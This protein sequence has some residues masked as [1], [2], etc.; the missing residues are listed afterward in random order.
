MAASDWDLKQMPA[1]VEPNVLVRGDASGFEQEVVAGTHRLKADE[2]VS[3]GGADT[4]AAPYD[5]LLGALGACTSMTLGMYA[6]R[7]KWPLKRVVVR[8]RHSRI[9]SEDCL[10][11]E[12]GGSVL[13]QIEREVELTGPLTVEQRS[14]LLEIA[15]RCPIHRAL[16][17]GIRSRTW[18]A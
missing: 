7:E 16:T 4:G 6:R 14:R 3:A 8:L 17:A 12:T 13:D 18:L 5:L 11:C 9:H 1:M 10:S 15:Q 2:P